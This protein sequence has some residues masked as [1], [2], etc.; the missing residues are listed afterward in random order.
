MVIGGIRRF[1]QTE[2][3]HNIQYNARY[4][5]KDFE[6]PEVIFGIDISCCADRDS[7]E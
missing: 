5:H 1:T 2:I 6:Q 3:R 7:L 4:Q